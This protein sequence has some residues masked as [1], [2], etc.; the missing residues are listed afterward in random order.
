MTRRGLPAR[1]R[2]GFS[3]WRV[4][5]SRFLK[6][7]LGE[8]SVVLMDLS[9]HAGSAEVFRVGMPCDVPWEVAV[10]VD[11]GGEGVEEVAA[12]GGFVR[13]DAGHADGPV[14]IEGDVESVVG[15]FGEDSGGD[16]AEGA[17]VGGDGV[18]EGGEAEV[19][20]EPVGIDLIA[21]DPAADRAVIRV[22]A[23]PASGEGG[24]DGGET[25]FAF[26]GFCVE[27]ADGVVVVLA[28]SGVDEDGVAGGVFGWIDEE[29]GVDED[30]FVGERAD[31]GVEGFEI[32]VVEGPLAGGAGAFAGGEV[33]DAAEIDVDACVV[34]AEGEGVVVHLDL[35]AFDG[36]RLGEGI[37]RG[38]EGGEGESGEG[39]GQL[40]ER[41]HEEAVGAVWACG[42][43]KMRGVQRARRRRSRAS[44]ERAASEAAPGSGMGANESFE[45]SQMVSKEVVPPG[46]MTR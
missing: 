44:A 27:G 32:G 11:A 38:V 18:G 46:E 23:I 20:P 5:T 15:G 33:D 35:E 25:A 39:G 1:R 26:V 40:T 37:G 12:G 34:D 19:V 41:G 13:A 28:G 7:T 22:F 3:R 36:R 10:G 4:R 29:D 16:G 17:F 14:V 42:Q 9:A 6:V 21:D 30:A 8:S 43:R 24:H 45:P 2:S 31:L